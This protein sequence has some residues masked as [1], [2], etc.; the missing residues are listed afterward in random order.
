MT[1]DLR[2]KFRDAFARL[3]SVSQMVATILAGMLTAQTW[4]WSPDLHMP[5][6]CVHTQQQCD[7]I[8]RLRRTGVC[9]PSSEFWSVQRRDK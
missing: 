8:V 3:A 9:T 1:R 6:T 5:R 7:E 4:C 2:D